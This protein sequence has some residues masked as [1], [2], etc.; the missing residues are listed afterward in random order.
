MF[1]RVEQH[2]KTHLFLLK[3]RA[4]ETELSLR[5]VQHL[6]TQIEAILE[7]IPAI[8][9]QAHERIIGGRKLSNKEENPESV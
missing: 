9:K 4:E 6:T 7:Q 1:K 8:I 5:V 2:A 3:E